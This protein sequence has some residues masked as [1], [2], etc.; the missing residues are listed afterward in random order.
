MNTHDFRKMHHSN[1]PAVVKQPS[2]LEYVG[3]VAILCVIT[4]VVVCVGIFSQ[5][6]GFL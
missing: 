6:G 5:T 2:F 4:L 1:K 3:Y